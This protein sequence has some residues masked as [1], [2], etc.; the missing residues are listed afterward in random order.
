M[1]STFSLVCC[2]LLALMGC[3]ETQTAGVSTVETENALLI[4][5]V[6]DDA[7]AKGALARV[8]RAR[9][10][11]DSSETDFASN[12]VVAEYSTDSK[13]FIAITKKVADSLNLGKIAVEVVG[14]KQGAF[15]MFA[16]ASGDVAGDSVTM[17]LEKFGSVKG[18]VLL[19][20]GDSSAVVRIYG[21]DR[22]VVTDSEGNFEIEDLP[23]Y[24]YSLYVNSRNASAEIDGKVT[25]EKSLDVGDIT[26]Q[27]SMAFNADD[28]ISSW[29]K[30]A[31]AA[32]KSG[33]AVVGF[34]RLNADNFDFSDVMESGEDAQIVGEDD[35]PLT[36][37]VAYWNDTLKQAVI[38]VLLDAETESLKLVWGAGKVT[39]KNSGLVSRTKLWSMVSAK[40]ATE[41]NSVSLVDFENGVKT[42]VTAPANV[43]DWYFAY[44]GDSVTTTP[45]TSNFLD[46][47]E[48]A[49]A[50]R[51]GKAFHWKSKAANGD[52]S[53]FGLWLS[54]SKNPSNFQAIDSVEYYIRGNGRYA[55]AFEAMDTTGYIRKAFYFDTLQTNASEWVRKVIKQNDFAEGTGTYANDGWDVINTRVTNFNIDAYDESEFWL[56]DIKF[57]G[58]NLDDL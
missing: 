4:Q 39:E 15:D 22:Y 3:S 32:R 17:S 38:Q 20:E 35:K 36:F 29:M 57:Y 25:S 55:F 44:Q 6:S 48:S 2:A 49:G 31:S 43:Y 42:N 16:L 30:N 53:Y 51:D 40:V 18:H 34:I 27:K 37:A 14:E 46:G 28:M 54:S 50:G 21:T 10:L 33:D 26:L 52:W 56:D 5:V 11:Q 47:V 13:G 12:G 1:K 9:Y 8:R 19:D 7:P 24:T 58:V 45:D 41:Q 23:P